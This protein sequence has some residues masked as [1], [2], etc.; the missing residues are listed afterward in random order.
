MKNERI[1][2]AIGDAEDKLLEGCEVRPRVA[3]R[4]PLWVK[5]GAV[6]ACACLV[7]VGAFA[8]G[9][10]PLA[11]K[12]P[13]IISSYVTDQPEAMYAAPENGEAFLLT[14]VEVALNENAGKDATYF[15]AVNLYR[16]G[17]PLRPEATRFRQS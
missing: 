13:A 15:V 14:N 8:L 5:W 16:D 7:A 17:A 3:K 4:Q 6:V 1:Y 12:N 9:Q 2:K 11:A 10:H